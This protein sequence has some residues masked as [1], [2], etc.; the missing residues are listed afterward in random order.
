MLTRMRKSPPSSAARA[1]SAYRERMR[2][3]G[4]VPRQV[5]IRP[6]HRELLGRIELLLRE[7]ELPRFLRQMESNQPM[8]TAWTTTVLYRELAQSELP[9][10]GVTLELIEGVEPAIAATMREHGDLLIQ[11][12]V[13]GDQIFV[14]APLCL[15]SQVKDRAR[16]NEACLRLNPINPLSNI[17]L[18]T[19]DGED[20]Y[21]V[22]GELSAR[23]PLAN[24]VEEILVLADNTL[25]AAEAFAH[26]IA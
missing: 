7:P 12:A 22:F 8:S 26:E 19:I 17:G 1:Q 13:A 6:G 5:F 2:E 21:V 25:D 9:A 24:V 15:G 4:L 18:Q 11:L 3:K 14:S 16:F 20:V 23:A 10:S